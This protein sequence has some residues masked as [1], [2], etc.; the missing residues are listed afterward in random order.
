MDLRETTSS[1][2]SH[3]L[4]GRHR[5]YLLAHLLRNNHTTIRVNGAPT[6]TMMTSLPIHLSNHSPQALERN[7]SGRCNHQRR[8][9][10]GHQRKMQRQRQMKKQKGLYGKKS[11]TSLKSERKKKTGR[12]GGQKMKVV[13]R[14][15]RLSFTIRKQKGEGNRR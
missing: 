1:R 7:L 14:D 11:R 8:N 6:I 9:E 10:N 5:H 4:R 12:T 15:S 13:R 2:G 3:R